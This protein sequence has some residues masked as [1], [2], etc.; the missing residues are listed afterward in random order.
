MYMNYDYLHWYS[1]NED[2]SIYSLKD[3]PNVILH[4]DI[5]NEKVVHVEILDN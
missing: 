2:L 3:F 1:D 5:E 4:I